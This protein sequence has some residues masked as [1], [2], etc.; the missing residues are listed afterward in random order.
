MGAAIRKGARAPAIAR[1]VLRF[2]RDQSAS[3]MAEVGI[4]M[5]LLV[6]IILAGVEVG[7]FALLQQK[8]NRT[9]VSMADLVAQSKTMT[10][11]DMAN[12]YEAARFVVRPFDLNAGVVI[13]SSVSKSGTNPAVVDWQCA[14]AGSATATSALGAAGATAALPAG[15]SLQAGQTVIYA[16][17]FYDFTPTFM[18]DVVA[19]QRIRHTA[20]FRPRF[21]SLGQLTAGPSAPAN[22]PT[23][24][25]V[26]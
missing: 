9:A 25:P 1:S 7:R 4:I 20:A 24:G 8:L 16:E 19:A 6:F 13:L 22:P 23:C 26:T 18:P 15:L 3:L 17:V 11:T 2:W 14:G 10:V 5:P 21:G 12:L